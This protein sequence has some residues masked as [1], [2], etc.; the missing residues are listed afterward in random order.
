[1]LY[2]QVHYMAYDWE[3]PAHPA[4]FDCP[5]HA[6]LVKD[7]TCSAQDDPVVLFPRAN[8]NLHQL[9]ALTDCA[10]LSLLCPPYNPS[11]GECLRGPVPDYQPLVRGCI[12]RW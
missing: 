5:A 8:G 1:M 6:R 4:D 9:T 12:I 3:E 7:R 10:V 2:G 11:Q